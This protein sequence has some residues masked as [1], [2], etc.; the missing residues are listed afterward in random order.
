[1]RNRPRYVSRSELTGRG[2][3]LARRLYRQLP[4]AVK[5]SAIF[6]GLKKKILESSLVPHDFMYNDEFYDVIMDGAS[7]SAP[8]IADSILSELHPTSIIDVGCGGGALLE[9][10]RDGGCTAI[11]LEYARAAI[12]R[13]KYRGLDVKQFD[14]ERDT[15][16]FDYRFDVAVSLEVA[17]HLPQSLADRYVDLL[18]ALSDTVVFS[19]ARP[20]QGGIAHFNEQQPEYWIAKFTVRGYV[21][22]CSL[23]DI[24]R[25]RWHESG[26]VADW[27]CSNVLIFRRSA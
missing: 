16:D 8:V 17:E 10:L 12:A 15:L 27:Y 25:T 19:A 24:W 11:G 21:C 7:C 9:A 20:G 26:K 4:L 6:A 22:D 23:S 13:C 5:Q 14:L 1:M 18:A 2:F 3:R